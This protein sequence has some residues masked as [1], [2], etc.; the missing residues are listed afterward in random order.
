MRYCAGSEVDWNDIAQ[1]ALNEALKR[2]PNTNRARNVIMFLGDGMGPATVTAGRIYSGQL[3]HQTGEEANLAFD[4]FPHVA[5]SKVGLIQFYSRLICFNMS[6]TS[7]SPSEPS[8]MGNTVS[9]HSLAKG[10]TR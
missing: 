3:N 9:G 6:L 8:R 4:K 10:C 5:L 2:Q 7:A 1:S